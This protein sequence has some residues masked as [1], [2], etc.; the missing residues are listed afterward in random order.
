MKKLFLYLI[1]F[2]QKYLTILSYGSCRYHPTCSSYAK[3]Q[4]EKNNIFVAFFH[5]IIRI[6]KCNPLFDGGFDYPKVN[7]TPKK[8]VFT[9]I[10]V[11]YWLIPD[12]HGK[13]FVIKNWERNKI[14]K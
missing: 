7:F 8:I 2:Y 12:G 6:L 13:F 11:E 3:T 5:T 9:K 1:S 4:F 10:C 14:K